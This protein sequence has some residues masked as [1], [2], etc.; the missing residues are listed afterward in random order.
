MLTCRNA[1]GV[2]GQRKV[3]NPGLKQATATHYMR[4]RVGPCISVS[5]GKSCAMSL[6][7]NRFRSNAAK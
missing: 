1:K 5:T 2:H 7:R 3:G 6:K 4:T